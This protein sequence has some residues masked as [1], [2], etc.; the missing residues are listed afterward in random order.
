MEPPGPKCC[1]NDLNR[2]KVSIKDKKAF[3]RK[4]RSSPN[5]ENEKDFILWQQKY[6][7]TK[8]EKETLVMEPLLPSSFLEQVPLQATVIIG[9]GKVHLQHEVLM[10]T[11]Q[12]INPQ[13]I[14]IQYSC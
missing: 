9:L 4:W 10:L 5:K 13:L 2:V 12:L 8:C 11:L 1:Q 14:R 7:L 3:S 6:K